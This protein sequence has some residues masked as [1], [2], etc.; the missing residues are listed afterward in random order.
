MDNLKDKIIDYKTYRF[1]IIFFQ[2]L[3]IIFQNHIQVWFWIRKQ[4]KS[5]YKKALRDEGGLRERVVHCFFPR[6]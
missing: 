4:E 2:N 5:G 1:N 3:K 6:K